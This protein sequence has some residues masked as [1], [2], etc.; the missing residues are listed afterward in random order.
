MHPMQQPSTFRSYDHSPPLVTISEISNSPLPN[1]P[2]PVRPR[3]ELATAARRA[4]NAKLAETCPF[5]E[6]LDRALDV[7]C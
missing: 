4:A 2:R 7:H 5:A 1:L 3:V 6:Q